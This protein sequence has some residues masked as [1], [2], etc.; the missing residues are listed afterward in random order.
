MPPRQAKRSGAGFV[1]N[2]ISD[3]IGDALEAEVKK[4]RVRSEEDQFVG[5]K[6]GKMEMYI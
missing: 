3:G 2:M 1:D 4:T 5:I 6:N